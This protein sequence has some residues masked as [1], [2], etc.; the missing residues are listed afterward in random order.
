MRILR[1]YIVRE[2]ILP[3]IIALGVL[4]C[5][6]LLGHLIQLTNLVI[7]K[8]VPLFVVS[9]VFVL[10]I[11]LLL[12]YTLPIA[13]LF[14]IIVA[15]SRLS[16]DNE[17]LA[18][19][20]SGIHILRLLVPLLML[21]IVISLFSLILNDRLIPYAHHEQRKL[22]KNIGVQNPTAMLEAGVFV[23]AFEGQ[24]IFVHTIDGSTLENITIYQ[25][26]EDRPTRTII[27]KH[28]QFTAIPNT[29]KIKLKLMDGT[30]DEPNLEGGNSFYKLNFKNYFMT[31]DLNKNPEKLKKKPKSMTLQE[32][33]D[34]IKNLEVLLIDTAFLKTEYMR[35]ITISLSPIAF[36]LLGFPIAVITNKREK[37]AN[38]VLAVFCGVGYYLLSLGAE[39][40]ATESIMP[41]HII[42]WGPNMIALI[43]ATI[44]NIKCA[45]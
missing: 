27:A 38:V 43:I 35:K 24:I 19:R 32:L 33:R 8:G 28:G 13:S 6:F 7:N 25:P 36:V 45:S 3:F 34:E 41:A 15:F 22:L 30:S 23:H 31:L 21:G 9:K 26:Q 37:S 42:M 16:A 17:I 29:D 12:G 1:N 5:V 10:L 14:A 40:L 44:L 4:T 2:C 20:A 11:P 39:A 18:M